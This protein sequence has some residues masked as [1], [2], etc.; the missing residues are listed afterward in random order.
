MNLVLILTED[1]ELGTA[2]TTALDAS[3]YRTWKARTE[4][5]ALQVASQQ[6]IAMLI[7]DGRFKTEERLNFVKRLKVDLHQDQV[8]CFLFATASQV[9]ELQNAHAAGVNEV[10]AWPSP[11]PIIAGRFRNL[12]HRAAEGHLADPLDFGEL[13][14]K[15]DEVE[16]PEANLFD[17]DKDQPDSDFKPRGFDMPDI[18]ASSGESFEVESS[19]YEMPDENNLRL[20]KTTPTHVDPAE[21]NEPKIDILSNEIGKGAHLED[22]REILVAHLGD[23]LAKM[24]DERLD[25]LAKDVL[26]K[27][28]TET[29]KKHMN[30]LVTAVVRAE[31][32][33][34]MPEL[35]KM[36]KKE[37]AS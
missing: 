15:V 19:R 3:M 29:A 33:R 17:F 27:R 32:K 23:A 7:I 16:N 12:F 36:L 37:L 30:K 26:D 4:M 5:D 9:P 11:T 8:P 18:G 24:T 25:A 31:L 22:E 13:A 2:A 21:T 35:V 10:C 20:R 6:P 34:A 1:S 28:F 14:P